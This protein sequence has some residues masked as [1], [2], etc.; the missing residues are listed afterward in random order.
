VLQNQH[1]R[2]NELLKIGVWDLSVYNIAKLRGEH[3]MANRILLNHPDAR[4]EG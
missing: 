1:D 4:R 3:D 2:V